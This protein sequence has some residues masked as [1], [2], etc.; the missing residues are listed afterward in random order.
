MQ[1]YLADTDTLNTIWPTLMASAVVFSSAVR[2]FDSRL[3]L[4]CL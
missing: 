4:G 2:G 3:G 1:L